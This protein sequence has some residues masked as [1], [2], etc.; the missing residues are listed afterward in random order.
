[1]LLSIVDSPDERGMSRNPGFG[2]RDRTKKRYNVAASRARDQMWICH[3][4]DPNRLDPTDLRRRLIVHAQNPEATEL[5][6]ESAAERAESEFERRV[7]ALL[8]DSGFRVIPQYRVGA[9]RIDMLVTDG[10]RTLAVECD[11]DQFHTSE[12]LE[13]DIA[14]QMILERSGG[15]RFERIRGS[16]FFRNPDL[17]MKPVFD[18]LSELGIMAR[19]DL[20]DS[21]DRDGTAI[22]DSIIDRAAAIRREWAVTRDEITPALARPKEG[23]GKPFGEKPSRGKVIDDA[24]AVLNEESAYQEHDDS[25]N[26]AERDLANSISVANS[27]PQLLLIT[28]NRANLIDILVA[29]GLSY[30]DK[31]SKGGSLWVIGGPELT[32]FFEALRAEGTLFVFKNEGGRAT[33]FRPGWYTTSNK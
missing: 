15:Y 29:K 30:E 11:G 9:Y 1:M 23:W 8:I 25:N 19:V 10:E 33:G 7:Q 28:S 13:Y 17:A 27:A 20:N 18:R 5:L 21:K 22:R 31:R 14:R 4:V 6:K 26:V 16:V 32:A 12:T 3:S 2:P 24:D